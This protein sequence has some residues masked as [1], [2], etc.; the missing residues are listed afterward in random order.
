MLAA[1]QLSCGQ[2]LGRNMKKEAWHYNE[3]RKKI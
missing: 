1:I 2:Y 3:R